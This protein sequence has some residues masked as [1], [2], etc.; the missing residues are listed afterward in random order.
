M[1]GRAAGRMLRAPQ[2]GSAH[3]KV[4]RV[5]RR[6]EIVRLSHSSPVRL[7]PMATAAAERSGTAWCALGSFGGGFLGGDEVDVDVH[8]EKDTVLTMTTQASTKVYQAKADGRAALQRLTATVGPGGLLVLSPDPLV[9]FAQS[10]YSQHL[11]FVLAADASA[12]VVDWLGAGRV[13]KGERWAFKEYRS[14]MEFCWEEDHLVESLALRSCDFPHSAPPFA[15]SV[16]VFAVGPLAQP[17]ARRLRAM[18]V[19]LAAR[20]GAR[21]GEDFEAQGPSVTG[22]A[23]M[24]VTEDRCTVGRLMAEKSEDVYRILHHC[25]LPLEEHLGVEPYADRVHGIAPSE[26]VETEIPTEAVPVTGKSAGNRVDLELDVR[27]ALV[28]SQLTDATLPVGGFAHSNGIEAASQL[29]LKLEKLDSLRTLVFLGSRSMLRLQGRFVQLAHKLGDQ[30]SL[31]AWHQ[32]DQDLQAH[33]ASNGVACRAS[34]LQGAGLLRVGRQWQ[35]CGRWPKKGHHATAFGL[36]AARLSLG[37]LATLQA[38]AYCT[39]RDSMSAAVRLN[40]LG[41]LM[42][43][44]VQGAILQDLSEELLELRDSS[45]EALALAGGCCPLLDCVHSGHDLLEARLFL[46]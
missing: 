20:R 11:R 4:S 13:A 6:S 21:V 3:L 15:A 12:V 8:M 22:Q 17:V 42:A 26:M 7:L 43:V 41:P 29:G 25:L 30:E 28:L 46:T 33:L 45:A 5:G 37:E 23:V 14:R 18:A 19:T 16:T 44:E 24:G 40:L 32:L 36:L 38:F 1:A 10:S 31:E 34:A 35:T 9:P 2:K 39:V 27:K